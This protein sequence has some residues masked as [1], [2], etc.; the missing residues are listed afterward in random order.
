M[1]DT[2]SVFG[3]PFHIWIRDKQVLI[4]ALA[5]ICAQWFD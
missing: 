3:G 1:N 5:G 4:M 2:E